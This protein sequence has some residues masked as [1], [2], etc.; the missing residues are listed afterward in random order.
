MFLLYKP[1]HEI[2]LGIRSTCVINRGVGGWNSW[3]D[4]LGHYTFL[5]LILLG[6]NI[7]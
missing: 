6:T 7:I 5:A 2:G 1:F 4:C 3:L